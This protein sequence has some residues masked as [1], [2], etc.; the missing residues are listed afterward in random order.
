MATVDPPVPQHLRAPYL[1]DFTPVAPPEGK[2]TE[3]EFFEWCR[4]FDKIRAE[5]VDGE[6]IVMSPVNRQHS[7][8]NVFL[9]MILHQFV[10]HHD[11]G[12]VGADVWWRFAARGRR[13][14]RAADIYFL[15]KANLDRMGPTYLD[16]AIDLA[17]EIVSPDSE[18]RD[19]REKFLD[20]QSV[21]VREY[22]IVDPLSQNVAMFSLDEGTKEF[23]AIVLTDGRFSSAVLP[24]FFLRPEWLWSDPKPTVNEVLRQL[25]I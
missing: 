25:G 11:L 7:Q 10:E 20:Y 2:L 17:I 18:E 23:R 5:W 1:D 16:G 8:L 15:A 13:A 3:E 22:W 19:Y 6:T 21:G 9:T 14:V 12:E 4:G 24:G